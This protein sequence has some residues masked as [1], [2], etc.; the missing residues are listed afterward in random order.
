VIS[1]LFAPGQLVPPQVAGSIDAEGTIAGSV[2]YP[3]VTTE[4]RGSDLQYEDWTAAEL[5][6]DA[7]I[8]RHPVAGWNGD[9]AV[10]GEQVEIPQLDRLQALRLEASGS[11][12][13]LA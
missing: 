10:E 2:E 6:M 9:V 12:A 7:D 3:D 8:Q 11:Q 13:A 4:L 5:T 1:R